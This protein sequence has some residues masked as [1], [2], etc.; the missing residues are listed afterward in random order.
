MGDNT[1][2][3][4]DDNLATIRNYVYVALTRQS[5]NSWITNCIPSLFRKEDLSEDSL[6]IHSS[7]GCFTALL[8]HLQ[9][10]QCL[11]FE[12]FI[13]SNRHYI[14]INYWM[15]VIQFLGD[16]STS[17][18]FLSNSWIWRNQST[19]FSKITNVEVCQ[20][21]DQAK[22]ASTLVQKWLCIND[23]IDLMST[24]ISENHHVKSISFQI[25]SK[26]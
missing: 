6:S 20:V 13:Y 12:R 4:W 9:T 2:L 5:Q 17:F 23:A 16:T 22:I 26:K 11:V 19:Y 14:L 8:Y 25:H 10:S 24:K 7:K 18:F 1:L 21:V 3:Q 15:K